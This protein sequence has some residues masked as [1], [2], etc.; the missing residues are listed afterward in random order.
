MKEMYGRKIER[1]D[2]VLLLMFLKNVKD[3]KEEQKTEKGTVVG[4]FTSIIH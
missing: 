2:L 1:F 4:I 3:N